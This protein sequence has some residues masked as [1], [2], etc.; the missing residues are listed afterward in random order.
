MSTS[1]AC[2]CVCCAVRSLE[3]PPDSSR[4]EKRTEVTQSRQMDKKGPAENKDE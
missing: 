1:S 4:R 3:A 2:V